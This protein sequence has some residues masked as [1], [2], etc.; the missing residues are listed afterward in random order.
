[1]KRFTHLSNWH[2]RFFLPGM[3][4]NPNNRPLSP[5]QILYWVH[6]QCRYFII[7]YTKIRN[8][9]KARGWLL[10]FIFYIIK[11]FF[12]IIQSIVIEW[13]ISPGKLHQCNGSRIYTVNICFV[14]AYYYTHNGVDE[15]TEYVFSEAL[16][17]TCYLPALTNEQVVYGLEWNTSKWWVSIMIHS[18]TSII[19]YS[20]AFVKYYNPIMYYSIEKRITAR[21]VYLIVFYIS[22]IIAPLSACSRRACRQRRGRRGMV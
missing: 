2:H 1:M 21:T 12:K 9:H 16:F 15:W 20:I 10:G 5:F 4:I 19:L 3:I 14:W 6:A 17:R 7:I 13:K 8:N 11:H 18:I 22:A